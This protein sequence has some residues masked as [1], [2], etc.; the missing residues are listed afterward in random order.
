MALISAAIANLFNG[1]SQ[2]PPQL[3]LASQCEASTNF[4]PTIATGLHKRPPTE[5]RAKLSSSA[6]ADAFVSVINRDSSERYVL[7]VM[8]GDLEVFDAF[9][10]VKKTVA[11]PSG[12]SYLDCDMARRDF[13]TMTVADYT[14][15]VNKTKQVAMT[16]AV[17]PGNLNLGYIV[18][19]YN[20]AGVQRT[21]TVR[22]NGVTQA[23]YSGADTAVSTAISSISS[24]LATNLGA[25]YSVTQPFNN[26]LR[27][28]CL[29]P[30][31]AW[32]MNASDDYGNS[33]MKV[34]KGS[35]AKFEDLPAQIDDQYVCYVSAKPGSD[36][37]GYYV[38]YDAASNSYIECPKPGAN[39]RLDP[40]TMPHKLVRE[41]DG[42]F[43]FAPMAWDERRTGDDI[44]SPL[45]TF[46]GRTINDVFFYRNRLGFLSDENVILSA[47]G[48]YFNFFPKSA[49]AVVDSDPI[50][51]AVANTKV[52]ILLYAVPFNKVLL[53][54][55][56]QT[57]F[58]LT[59]GDLLTPK[60]IKA[61]PVTEFTS[62]TQC[63]PVGAGHELFFIV[64]R[65]GWSGMREYFVDQESLSN[66]AA[67]VTAHVPAY[68]PAG[69]FK[70]AVST[71]EDVLFA[72][73]ENERNA[74]YAYKYF[75]GKDEKV[76]SAWMRFVLDPGDVILG[77]EFIGSVAHLVILRSDG[78]YFEAMSMQ[79]LQKDAGLPYRVLLD[80]KTSVTGTYNSATDR[81][82][83][84]LPWPVSGPVQ[85]VLGAAFGSRVGAVVGTEATGTYTVAAPGDYSAGPAIVGLKYEGRYKFSEQFMK[86]QNNVAITSAKVKMRRMALSYVNSGYFRVEVTPP[87]RDTSTYV[88]SGKRLGVS[89]LKLGEPSLSSGIF[90][91]PIM[92]D[93]KGVSIEL[94][95]DSPL[96]SIFQNAEWEGEAVVQARRV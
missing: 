36:G 71:A 11:F 76:Q 73:T 46:V 21:M 9:T 80:R 61:D 74:I 14:F 6:T 16:S 25:G 83:W 89:G 87:A 67:D 33:T 54:F 43:T 41:A 13:S 79:T 77:G 72:L 75:W 3:R 48:N 88:F 85:A 57:Q 32:T 2:Q 66:D 86:D 92:A 49:T 93:T 15:V 45:P 68:V 90:P 82:T 84:T 17:A 62:S 58:Q 12:K 91:F 19:S 64:E 60:S 56:D 52:S 42:T 94:V 65:D 23:T 69:V 5:F 53:L 26:T 81:T 70:M 38:R 78:L 10:G 35:V 30:A 96:P 44:S 63:R 29:N 39:I 47:S 55:S 95:N 22:I 1:V 34:I 51:E 50:D 4:Y 8:D 27:V 31:T 20:G 59:G 37:K 7:T 18:F 24:Q 40:A 28:Q